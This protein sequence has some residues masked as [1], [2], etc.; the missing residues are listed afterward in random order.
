[1]RDLHLV[2][3]SGFI[4]GIT[5]SIPMEHKL[6]GTSLMNRSPVQFVQSEVFPREFPSF[7]RLTWMRP[8]EVIHSGLGRPIS[9]SQATIP[10]IL[11]HL[12]RHDEEF[13]QNY[14]QQSTSGPIISFVFQ[15]L[16]LL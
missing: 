15:A 1:M 4:G 10:T 9:S 13:V 5:A 2:R 3:L 8:V 14:M 11:D 6:E 12:G 16:A 7:A